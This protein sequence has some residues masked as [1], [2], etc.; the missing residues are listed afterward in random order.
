MES[1]SFSDDVILKIKRW[2]S[3]LETVFLETSLVGSDK[4]V[5]SKILNTKSN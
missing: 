2:N 1:T 5:L 4:R 3:E